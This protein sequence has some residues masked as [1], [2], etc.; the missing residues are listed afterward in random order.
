LI[1]LIGSPVTTIGQQDVIARP[2]PLKKK[3]LEQQ[4]ESH[5][6]PQ[7]QDLQSIAE[8]QKCL[9]GLLPE[10]PPTPTGVIAPPQEPPSEPTPTQ[11]SLQ[12]ASAGSG[13]GAVQPTLTV[14][15]LLKRKL[16]LRG[17]QKRLEQ[18]EKMTTEAA[19]GR[20]AP[21]ADRWFD[22]AFP[23]TGNDDVL[24][25]SGTQFFSGVL[26]PTKTDQV[27][28]LVEH[29]DSMGGGIWLLGFADLGAINNV[30]YDSRFN[31]FIVD[32]RAIYFV[33]VPPKSLAVLCRAID[34]DKKERVGVSL[35]SALE[36]GGLLYGEVP[37]DSDLAW[38][39]KIADNFLGGIVFPGNNNWTAGYRFGNGFRPEKPGESWYGCVNFMF[40]AF[41]F[42][43][44]QKELR[45][46][47]ANLRVRL[48]PL[49]DSVAKDGGFLPDYDAI[50]LG[51]IPQQYGRN[52]NH[53]AQNISYYRRERIIDRMLAYCEVAAF[54]RTLKQAGF[55]LEDLAN[56][57]SR[58]GHP[59]TEERSA[60]I[61][62][63]N[64]LNDHWASY[65]Q[66]IQA[67][68]AYPNWS[69]PPYDMYMKIQKEQRRTYWLRQFFHMLVY[70][71][72]FLL[73][74]CLWVWRGGGGLLDW[75]PYI[76]TAP[77]PWLNEHV[78]SYPIA[79][80]KGKA[81]K[82][83]T[84]EEFKWSESLSYII[85]APGRWLNERVE[86]IR[87][88]CKKAEE[89]RR[90]AKEQAKRAEAKRIEFEKAEAERK[91][92]EAKRQALKVAEA[93]RIAREKVE[94]DRKVEVVRGRLVA[95]AERIALRKADAERELK[96][97]EDYIESLLT[98]STYDV[99]LRESNIAQAKLMEEVT[100]SRVKAEVKVYEAEMV[101]CEKLIA[102]VLQTGDVI[103]FLTEALR[104]PDSHVRLKSVEALGDIAD[105]QAAKVL[106]EATL[107]EDK[108]VRRCAVSALVQI[109]LTETIEPLIAHLTKMLHNE[110]SEVR[111]EAVRTLGDI[112]HQ[113]AVE[114]LFEALRD[115]NKFVHRQAWSEIMQM[116]A[117]GTIELL[118]AHLTKMLHNE[119]SEVRLEAIEVL[120]R[121][122]VSPLGNIRHQRAVE[123]LLEGLH[124]R[125][126]RVRYR[127]VMCTRFLR[128]VEPLIAHLTKMLHNEDSEVRIEAVEALGDIGDQRA[129]KVLLEA[130]RDEDKVVRLHAL[131]ALTRIKTN[132]P[133]E[134]LIAHL[135]KM[136]HNEDSKV[137]LETVEA[138]SAFA[139]K[140]GGL[141]HSPRASTKWPI[142]PLIAP[143]AKMLHNKDSNV[144]LETVE[145]LSA[146]ARNA[147]GLAGYPRILELLTD[148][149]NDK[150]QNV[151]KEA[152]FTI[153]R[154]WRKWKPSKE[155]QHNLW[156]AGITLW[157]RWYQRLRIWSKE[158]S[159]SSSTSYGSRPTSHM[160]G[161]KIFRS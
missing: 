137:R 136:L 140:A 20:G 37:K 121:I 56:N 139:E 113:R 49:S 156:A 36:G 87:I 133:V 75:P 1:V 117:K 101:A 147:D 47:D 65:L 145:A 158:M 149:L 27:K 63:K 93:E 143:L 81:A 132:W 54:I 60:G 43:I 38:D 124:D 50:R 67:D 64:S 14:E 15:Q 91:A 71:L 41:N 55:D 33:R 120:G 118:V 74:L 3:E 84:E 157:P 34:R 8:V 122:F 85:T 127:T 112:R 16:G 70:S 126:S 72:F 32:D 23:R 78:K 17:F 105:D 35:G 107:D 69:G 28:G 51:R 160:G 86:S 96:Q 59:I 2:K 150:D 53:V 29:F 128:P 109:N 152:A 39:L 22:N 153:H 154:N 134:P 57:I 94:T 68:K 114:V 98:S 77:V 103:A 46:R 11:S 79:R 138:L 123:V 45:L 111:M 31:A 5:Q 52:G 144:R 83:L 110:D 106:F 10:P 95:E 9:G 142:E 135:T 92:E 97:A 58:A 80:K 4:P 155:M 104:D 90:L 146:F 30:W 26:M 42:E 99:R 40:T 25:P 116:E 125:D 161:G 44:K 6:L 13:E 61:K 19:T 100:V 148:A 131:S 102:L 7:A 115:E 159:S 108:F 73:M 130:L 141:A 24:R 12:M 48:V 151:I 129:M 89:A 66:E 62:Q 119:D 82:R 21:M 88:A 76:V 18:F